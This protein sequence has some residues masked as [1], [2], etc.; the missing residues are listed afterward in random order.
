MLLNAFRLVV[1]SIFADFTAEREGLQTQVF[2]ALDAY[3]VAKRWGISE[4]AGRDQPTSASK[5]W[6]PRTAI[7]LP[8]GAH[9]AR[10]RSGGG[11]RQATSVGHRNMRSTHSGP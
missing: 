8:A 11:V 7:S 5:K 3:S 10:S 4:K 1:S 2:P 6:R 9:P